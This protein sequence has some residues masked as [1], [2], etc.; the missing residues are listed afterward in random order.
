MHP[1]ENKPK[2]ISVR[3]L[4]AMMSRMS[5]WDPSATPAGHHVKTSIWIPAGFC[6]RSSIHTL[7]LLIISRPLALDLD[8][9]AARRFSYL[10]PLPIGVLDKQLAVEGDAAS[11]LLLCSLSVLNTNLGGSLSAISQ[12]NGS[13]GA[14]VVC[15]HT[16][17]G[18]PLH[19]TLSNLNGLFNIVLLVIFCRRRNVEHTP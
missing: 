18:V 13:R 10:R 2:A 9:E 16:S 19:V 12:S 14:E 11:D 8:T 17:Y 4:S 1:S 5:C 6:Q 7:H 3:A 15:L